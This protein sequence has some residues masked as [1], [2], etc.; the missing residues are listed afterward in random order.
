M[1]FASDRRG[2]GPKVPGVYVIPEPYSYRCPIKHCRDACDMSCM[3]V[4]LNMFDMAS[5]GAPA[6]II[7]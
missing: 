4:G 5:E 7:A 3:K 6:A 1:S 2:Y